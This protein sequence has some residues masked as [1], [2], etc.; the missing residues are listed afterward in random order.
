MKKDS[1]KIEKNMDV[2]VSYSMSSTVTLAILCLL[3]IVIPLT[4]INNNHYKLPL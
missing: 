1:K 3:Q 4:I 2:R